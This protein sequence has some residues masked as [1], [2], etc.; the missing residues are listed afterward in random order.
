MELEIRGL[1]KRYGK[2][3][4]VRGVE[5]RVD[6]GAVGLGGAAAH[7]LRLFQHQHPALVARQIPRDCAAG[8]TGA[9]DDNVVQKD[10]S[11]ICQRKSGSPNKPSGG[12]V[13]LPDTF[14]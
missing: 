12:R 3:T 1:G 14:T 9:D 8:H 4:A 11:F 5:A 10:S 13:G 6:D 7:V 2:K